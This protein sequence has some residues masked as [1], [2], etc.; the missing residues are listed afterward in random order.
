MATWMESEVN[1]AKDI[2][3][4][5]KSVS[6]VRIA[7]TK[8]K[9][10]MPR[11]IPPQ[12][13]EKWWVKFGN[14]GSS[15]DEIGNCCIVGQ[16]ES[17]Y[18]STKYGRQVA[19][20]IPN[21][22]G[23]AHGRF[24][25]ILGSWFDGLPHASGGQWINTI[26]NNSVNLVI[27]DTPKLGAVIEWPGHVAIVEYINED[28]SIMISQSGWSSQ[29]NYHWNTRFWVQGPIS[30]P[31][32][33][34]YGNVKGF[35]Y[36]P[37]T[38]GVTKVGPWTPGPKWKEDLS[39]YDNQYY[40]K[41]WDGKG[42][43]YNIGQGYVGGS[44][45]TG[46]SV[47]Y[48]E[49]SKHP[50]RLL[51]S[52][53][54]AHAGQGNDGYDWVK[55]LTGC[56]TQGW[57]AATICAGSIANEYES[58]IPTDT[59]S[60]PALGRIIVE[61]KGGTYFDGSVRGGTDTPQIGDICAIY[62]GVVTS[63]DKYACTRLG[64]VMSI[65]EN[66]L[67]IVEGDS[68]GCILLNKRRV[69]D[70]LWY[71]RPDWT[72]EG[73][74][75]ECTSLFANPLYDT[76]STREDATL[77]EVAYMTDQVEPS[78]DIDSVRLSAI[79]YTGLL[80]KIY[81]AAGFSDL[82]MVYGSTT[83]GSTGTADGSGLASIH[84]NAPVIFN[85]LTEKGLTAAQA[86][87]FLGNIQQECGYDAG[88]VDGAAAGLCQWESSRQASMKKYCGANW[89]NN[90]SGQAEFIWVELT[91]SE[92]AT[93]TALQSQATGND[94]A[95]AVLAAEIICT[96]YERAG[97]PMMDNRR[98]YTRDAWKC[99]QFTS[100][101]GGTTASLNTVVRTRSGATLT[102]GTSYNI[103]SN[104]VQTG[105]IGDYTNFNRNW[106][107]VPKQLYDIW[108]SRGKPTANYIATLDGYVLI[109]CKQRF[110]NDGDLISVVLE[111]GTFFNAIIG[112]IKRSDEGNEWG[113]LFDMSGGRKGTS[114]IEFEANGNDLSA[115]NA[116]LTA[117]G[118]YKKKVV[119]I[120]N[121]GSWLNG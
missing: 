66:I 45:T 31:Y 55:E 119:Q 74:A 80:G 48:V 30:S 33:L 78:I 27:G 113:H 23:Y 116:G 105:I 25:E 62:K 22:V 12:R 29:Y 61:E 109:A 99:I 9:I 3:Q 110:G 65:D 68:Q 85:V 88:L 102:S 7:T 59:F 70:I 13:D 32:N 63:T 106:S 57:S 18:Y 47:S 94:E 40:I 104:I 49:A 81:D 6:N 52:S 36:N 91:S 38:E 11:T 111:D 118:W 2:A 71:V 37:G 51:I 77:R 103:S 14:G 107:Y 41:D 120:V 60:C 64:I 5:E 121:Y 86:A 87:G 101:S 21:C 114:I 108:V 20:V 28:G 84:P 96:K 4:G 69:Q 50:A 90:V 72:A 16:N 46:S 17:W 95:T 73:G 42:P 98:K 83:S 82:Q 100:S 115:V 8:E 89:K 44:P 56:D 35:I 24:C 34:S 67:T 58:I 79:N 97:I 117:A 112:D 75:A 93:M 26:R 43:L 39:K 19:N 10:F 92:S 1:T 54:V 53:I 76:Q 15:N